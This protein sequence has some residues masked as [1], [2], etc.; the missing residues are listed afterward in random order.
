M[1]GSGINPL[2]KWPDWRTVNDAIID[3]VWELLTSYIDW[4]VPVVETVVAHPDKTTDAS[5]CYALCWAATHESLF[6]VARERA[7]E[8][9]AKL[10]VDENPPTTVQAA[11]EEA[12]ATPDPELTDLGL[13][14]ELDV[15]TLTLEAPNAGAPE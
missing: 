1:P 8:R 15:D 5:L 6:A 10:S 12:L 14:D 11:A 9:L 4:Y 7:D 2:L 13:G 3:L